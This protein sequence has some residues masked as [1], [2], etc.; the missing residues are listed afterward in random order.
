MRIDRIC[1]QFWTIFTLIVISHIWYMGLLVVPILWPD[2]GP[3]N[4]VCRRLSVL[5]IGISTV[6]ALGRLGIVL[7]LTL[8]RT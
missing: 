3:E 2:S 7:W 5:L 8:G 6:G 1:S 4:A